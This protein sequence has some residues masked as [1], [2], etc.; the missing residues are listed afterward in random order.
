MAFRVCTIGQLGH[1]KTTL[2][3]A[4]A[5]SQSNTAAP[6]DKNGIV[7]DATRVQYQTPTRQ[8]DHVDFAG[9]S[10]ATKYFITQGSALNAVILVVS[11]TEGPTQQTRDQLLLAKQ[12]GLKSIVLLL[13][14]TD[15]IDD[16]AV[17]DLV[18][19]EVRELVI[20]Y[21]FV[22]ADM[23]VVRGS[24]L[25]AAQGTDKSTVAALLQSLDAFPQRN[26]EQITSPN[27]EAL[28]YLRTTAEG[29]RRTPF[30]QGYIPRLNFPVVGKT[31]LGKI[32]F[33]GGVTSGNAGAVITL[34]VTLDEGINLSAKTTRFSIQ[35]GG[36]D[37]GHGV[38]TRVG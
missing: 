34:K 15:L 11:A 37:I 1:G 35:E 14:K 4:L 31:I 29:G 7:Y 30:Y 23:P 32:E 16:D 17:L 26:N 21:D 36:L 20:E 9:P 8:Y 19:D 24:A 18:E 12:V 22:G 27:F 2:K 13:N 28:V 25:K 33:T 5:Q 3:T 10:D 6:L 38:V